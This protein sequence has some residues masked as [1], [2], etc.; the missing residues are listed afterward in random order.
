[1]PILNSLGALK[2]L[3]PNIG[4]MA[5]NFWVDITPGNA[6]GATT[7]D[8]MG[9]LRLV[10]SSNI[11]TSISDKNITLA[12]DQYSGTAPTNSIEKVTG[13]SNNEILLGY[14]DSV[15]TPKIMG[16]S[17]ATNGNVGNTGFGFSSSTRSLALGNIT[18]DNTGNY[19]LS[20]QGDG[21]ATSSYGILTKYDTSKNII[22]NKSVRYP[23]KV[24]IPAYDYNVTVKDAISDGTNTYAVG[25]YTTTDGSISGGFVF[26]S[27]ANGTMLWSKELGY[28]GECI[29]FIDNQANV[30][31]AGYASTGNAKGFLHKIATSNGAASRVGSVTNSTYPNTITWIKTLNVDNTNNVVIGG[32]FRKSTGPVKLD[33]Y[34]IGIDGNL[35]TVRYAKDVYMSG[36]GAPE[37]SIVGTSQIANQSLYITG[38]N[39]VGGSYTGM[40]LKTL[41]DG[42]TIGTGN[43]VLGTTTVSYIDAPQLGVTFSTATVNSSNI[44]LDTNLTTTVGTSASFSSTTLPITKLTL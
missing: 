41:Y 18:V 30:I 6:T 9:R 10:T 12:I 15:I 5:D 16:V 31:V 33:G 32:Q 11:L 36:L 38:V 37:M 26:K 35:T 13:T 8:P 39:N 24:T 22:W 44:F 1:M 7:F 3:L 14:H 40:A 34:V 17:I 29:S 4:G 42:T 27:A 25:N 2:E 28:N 43:Y 23:P 19:I 20:G 21:G